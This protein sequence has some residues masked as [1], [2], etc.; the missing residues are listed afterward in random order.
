MKILWHRRSERRVGEWAVTYVKQRKGWRM[1]FDVGKARE[2]LENAQSRAH[3]P[4]FTYAT[5]P[6]SQLILILQ[7]FRHFTYVT[8]HSPTLPALYLRQNSISNPSAASPT[9]Q[10]I[11]QPFFR[12]SYVTGFSLTSPGEQPTLYVGLYETACAAQQS[13]QAHCQ[14]YQ[15]WRKE[16]MWSCLILYKS[17][18]IMIWYNLCNTVSR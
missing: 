18:N 16:K 6:T 15:L 1:S 13:S 14:T 4:S 2:G 5:S 7:A 11:L 10:L 8:A 12:L 3:S 9:S 17:R